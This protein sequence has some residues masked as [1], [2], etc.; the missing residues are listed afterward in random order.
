MTVASDFGEAW[1]AYPNKRSRSYIPP[2]AIALVNA[3]LGERDA[4]ITWLHHAA[5]A[6][7]VHLMFLPVDPKWD[8][9]RENSR[10]KDVLAKCNFMH[11]G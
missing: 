5:A 4:A 1:L 9:Y 10:F 3:G 2:Y 11:R 7:D 8:E 6:R